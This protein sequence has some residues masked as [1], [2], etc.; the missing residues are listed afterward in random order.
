MVT[1]GGIISAT[2]SLPAVSMEF[3]KKLEFFSVYA[4]VAIFPLYSFYLFLLRHQETNSRF[5]WL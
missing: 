3:W 1:H 4:V 5:H 2:G